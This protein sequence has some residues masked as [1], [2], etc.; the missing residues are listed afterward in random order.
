MPANAH[1]EIHYGPYEA[2]GI[3]EHRIARLEGMSSKYMSPLSFVVNM[4]VFRCLCVCV[5][6][7]VCARALRTVFTDKIS[8]LHK[9]VL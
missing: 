3:V 1:V 8:V 7:C 6:V 5:C 9:Y 4:L 2:C